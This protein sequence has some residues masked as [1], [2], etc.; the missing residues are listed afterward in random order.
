[1]RRETTTLA[2]ALLTCAFAATR[3]SAGLFLNE[4]MP[5]NNDT[6]ADEGGDYDDWFEL[7]NSSATPI[8][9]FGFSVSDSPEDT[10]TWA[11]PYTTIPGHGFLIVWADDDQEQGPLHAPFKLSG[12]GESL[13]LWFGSTIVD[14]VSWGPAEADESYS[15]LPDGVGEWSWTDQPTPEASNKA[16]GIGDGGLPPSRPMFALE[17]A[18]PNPFNP[19]T[20]VPIALDAA[21]KRLRVV[22]Y[23]VAGRAV[24]TLYDAPADAGTMRLSWQASDLPSGIYVV[25]AEADG[26]RQSRKLV[27]LK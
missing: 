3:A 8:S 5:I 25:R 12:S 16:T 15:R 14:S 9:L 18:R 13:V 1:M 19:R 17:P 20:T 4:A 11:F 23:D 27:L 6:I 21:V 24:E 10:V 22:A 2:T 26:Q 7:Y